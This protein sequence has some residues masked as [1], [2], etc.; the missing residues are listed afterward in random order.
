MIIKDLA[1]KNDNMKK[2]LGRA[3]DDLDNF[4]RK[5][6]LDQ[7][8]LDRMRGALGDMEKDLDDEV[9]RNTALADDIK[10]IQNELEKERRISNANLGKISNL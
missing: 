2:D 9:R 10:D 1:K 6:Q 5:S 4:R 7:V 8:E 3:A